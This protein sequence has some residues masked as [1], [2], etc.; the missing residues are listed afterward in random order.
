MRIGDKVVCI[1]DGFKSQYNE[2]LPRKGQMYTIREV[3]NFGCPGIRLVEIVN[4]SKQYRNIYG[5]CSFETD[6]F[7]PVDYAYGTEVCEAIET[8]FKKLKEPVTL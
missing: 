8:E 5:E 4:P 6:A 7:R 2:I 1:N 3:T